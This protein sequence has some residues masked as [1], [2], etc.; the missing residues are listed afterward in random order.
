VLYNSWQSA[1]FQIVRDHGVVDE[2]IPAEGESQSERQIRIGEMHD[3][4]EREIHGPGHKR[5]A[6]LNAAEVS[7]RDKPGVGLGSQSAPVGRNPSGATAGGPTDREA[8]KDQEEEGPE[9]FSM[10]TPRPKEE[11]R[12]DAASPDLLA[13]RPEVGAMWDTEACSQTEDSEK[14][15]ERVDRLRDILGTVDN[16]DMAGIDFICSVE[17]LIPTCVEAYGQWVA[18]D[19]DNRKNVSRVQWAL[20]KLLELEADKYPSQYD[21][22]RHIFALGRMALKSPESC[23]AIAIA[24]WVTSSRGT[25]VPARAIRPGL[26]QR[27]CRVDR[28]D[29]R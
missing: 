20:D 3:S 24:K 22:K 16:A 2:G 28:R 4:I 21:M 29:Q 12:E 26:L 7:G 27:S 14:M 15:Q 8:E 19:Y 18:G 25:P 5:Q 1:Y 10:A 11:V 6:L 23:R 13:V 17:H 9:E